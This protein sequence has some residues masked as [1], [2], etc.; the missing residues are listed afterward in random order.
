MKKFGVIGYRGKLGSL[1]IKRADFVP[2]EC[3]VTSIDSVNL[4]VSPYLGLLDI[5]VNCAAISSLD[6][7]EKDYQKA[8]KV[9]KDGLVNLH[10]VFGSRV[11][12]ISSDHVFNG[13][14]WYTPS[15]D[16]K[17]SPISAYGFSK[18]GAEA[19]SK[20]FGGKV[21]R[22]SRAVSLDDTDIKQILLGVKLGINVNAPT[23][24]HRNYIHREFAVDGI[25]Y[26]VNNWDSIKFGTV[27]YAST[28]Q[29]SMYD[30]MRTLVGALGMN[31]NLVKPRN[32]YFNN[33]PR[34]KRGGLRVGLAK[35]LG[36]PM[37]SIS[38]TVAKLKEDYG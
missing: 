23:F 28:N 5:V 9:N 26:M 12:S 8:L 13:K 21:I 16:T 27:H 31:V 18:W 29:M 35:K 10:K 36:F 4:G 30:F 17:V 2:I 3:D 19:V 11:L 37:Y 20:I 25:E 38:D 15:E 22:L 14:S 24:F 6:E 1:L 33:A 7:C 32:E 34:P